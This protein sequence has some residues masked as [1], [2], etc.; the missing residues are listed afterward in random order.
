MSHDGHVIGNGHLM[1]RRLKR[2]MVNDGCYIGCCIEDFAS[3]KGARGKTE[4]WKNCR[5]RA[6]FN[7]ALLFF[8]DVDPGR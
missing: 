2:R 7:F 6:R 4:E 8:G 5:R 1:R 3:H